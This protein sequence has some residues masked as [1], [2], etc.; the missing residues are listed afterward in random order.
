MTA[1]LTRARQTPPVERGAR[2]TPAASET[3]DPLEAMREQLRAAGDRRAGAI[4]AQQR[5]DEEIADLAIRAKGLLAVGEIA[6][7]ARYKTR[8]AVYD[9]IAWRSGE[10]PGRH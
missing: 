1:S 3:R 7:L 6:E 5:A 8:K 2:A 4:A 10:K 9:L